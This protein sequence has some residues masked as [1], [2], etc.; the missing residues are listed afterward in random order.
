MS[1]RDKNYIITMP[2]GTRWGIPVEVIA[3]H[4][5]QY[6]A[7]DFDGNTARSLEAT[8][9]AFESNSYIIEDWAKNVMTW[10]D[11]KEEA[12]RVVASIPADAYHEGW[13]TGECKIK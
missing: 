1:I 12:V 5:A 3:V 7:K 2:D 10:A 4:H 8:W 11:V 9:S 13:R 6:F